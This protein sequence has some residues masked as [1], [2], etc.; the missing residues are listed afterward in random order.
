MNKAR[1]AEKYCIK[2]V[3]KIGCLQMTFEYGQE[4]P[5]YGFLK[6]RFRI[7]SHLMKDYDYQ[8]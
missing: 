2:H 7:T 6:T 1:N 4:S 8:V 5:F 3:G